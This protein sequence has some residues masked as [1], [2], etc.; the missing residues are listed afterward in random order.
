MMIVEEKTVPG[1]VMAASMTADAA[2]I[3]RA[4]LVAIEAGPES[5]TGASAVAHRGRGGIGAALVPQEVTAMN[6]AAPVVPGTTA[7][8]AVVPEDLSVLDHQRG[9]TTGKGIVTEAEIEERALAPGLDAGNAP[10][11]ETPAQ[12]QTA[13]LP[14]PAAAL[15]HVAGVAIGPVTE[16]VIVAVIDAAALAPVLAR[17]PDYRSP[18]TGK[19]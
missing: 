8:N 3:D 14:A 5:E 10:A 9:V 1:D 16:T 18:W 2:I 6:E 11:R 17:L 4:H 7:T 13:M 19:T 12:P 15:L